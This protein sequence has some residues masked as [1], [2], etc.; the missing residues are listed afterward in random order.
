MVSVNSFTKKYK[1]FTVEPGTSENDLENKIYYILN[2][3]SKFIL[4][5]IQYYKPWRS[6]VFV[7]N[8]AIVWSTG[9]MVDVVDA[10]ERITAFVKG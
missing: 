3:R 8:E 6:F 1:F 7:S 10:I 5:S 9:C 4:G 2:N